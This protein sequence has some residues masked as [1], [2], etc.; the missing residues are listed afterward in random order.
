M[1]KQKVKTVRALERGLDVLMEVQ[2]SSGTS[3]NELHQKLGL[4]KPT[5]LRMLV[6]LSKSGL[7]WQRIADGTYHASAVSLARPKADLTSEIAEIASPFMEELGHQVHLPSAIA[8]PRFDHMTI[9]ETNSPLV[10]LQAA[11]LGP[12]GTK[13]SYIHTATGR[14][15][16]AHC[17][18]DERDTLIE[19]LRPANAGGEEEQALRHILDEVSSRGYSLRDPA[20]SWF[21]RNKQ[22]VLRD[23]RRSM[24]VAVRLHGKPVASLNITCPTRDGEGDEAVLCHLDLLRRT[25]AGIGRALERLH[26]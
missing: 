9:V 12:V 4:P 8:V 3:L 26:A 19:R 24:A 18:G 7:V 22:T 25:A 13:L 14:A 17:D 16:L 10:Q 2:S 21:D 1:L 20:H 11:M 15:Y 5:L 6:T 23:G